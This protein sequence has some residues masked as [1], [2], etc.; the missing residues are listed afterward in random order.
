MNRQILEK[1]FPDYMLRKLEFLLPKKDL[2][3]MIYNHSDILKKHLG[4]RSILYL[5]LYNKTRNIKF[6]RGIVYRLRTA[7]TNIQRDNTLK[8][9]YK[10]N[11]KIEL[12][13]MNKL[14]EFNSN[15]L[16]NLGNA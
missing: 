6:I 10:F 11:E 7:L 16:K 14:K 4:Y 3:K 5:K 9:E 12:D 2:E 15:I 8:L 1:Y 13:L